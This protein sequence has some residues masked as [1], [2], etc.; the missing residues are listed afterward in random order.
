MTTPVL[1]ER[2]SVDVT[3]RPMS[4]N[5]DLSQQRRILLHSRELQRGEMGEMIKAKGWLARTH[6]TDQNPVSR[7][8]RSSA[9]KMLK[10]ERALSKSIKSLTRAI[11]KFNRSC[12]VQNRAEM[13]ISR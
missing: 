3:G 1:R 7:E 9:L 5:T 6:P 13:R 2:L 12:T 8:E 4:A 10:G 11:E